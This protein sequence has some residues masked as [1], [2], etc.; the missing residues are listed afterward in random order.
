M[1]GVSTTRAKV[2]ALSALALMLAGQPVFAAP[3]RPSETPSVATM[4][5][6]VIRRIRLLTDISFPPG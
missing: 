1:R 5:R 4:L 3:P 6:S 2:L